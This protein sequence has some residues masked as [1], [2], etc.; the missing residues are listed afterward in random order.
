MAVIEFMGM[1]LADPKARNTVE[2]RAYRQA[3]PITHVSTN[4]APTLFIHDDADSTVPFEQSEL[5]EKHSEPR[6]CITFP[7]AKN[8]TDYMGE[9]TKWLDQY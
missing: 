1:R 7:G 5:M 2:D 3:S 4:A 8:P 6:V 9:M